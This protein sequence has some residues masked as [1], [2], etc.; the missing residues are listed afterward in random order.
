MIEKW[1]VMYNTQ[2]PHSALGYRPSAPAACNPWAPNLNSQP[3]VVM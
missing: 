1:R 2:R 3:M